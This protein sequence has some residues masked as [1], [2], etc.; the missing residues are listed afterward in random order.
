MFFSEDPGSFDE[1]RYDGRQALAV[2]VFRLYSYGTCR[3]SR[4]NR[5]EKA[6][7]GEAIVTTN[8]PSNQVFFY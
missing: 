6:V 5:P 3:S 4:L 1:Y 7:C 8:N 2:L